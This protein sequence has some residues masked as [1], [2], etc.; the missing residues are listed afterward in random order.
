M[1]LKINVSNIIYINFSSNYFWI[2]YGHTDFNQLARKMYWNQHRWTR[3]L[4]IAYVG[5]CLCLD[6]ALG[7]SS[8]SSSTMFVRV[9][10]HNKSTA[11][12]YIK[13][14]VW[15]HFAGTSVEPV[16]SPDNDN[17]DERIVLQCLRRCHSRADCAT[18]KVSIVEGSTTC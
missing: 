9:R 2:W 4:L 5:V 12:T 13:R 7:D 1:L 17:A 6:I 11:R 8:T 3:V 10:P 16:R 14:S 18:V 15:Q